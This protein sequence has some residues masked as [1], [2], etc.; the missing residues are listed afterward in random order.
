MGKKDYDQTLALL[1][2]ARKDEMA[3]KRTLRAELWLEYT[4]RMLLARHRV[5][6]LAIEAVAQGASLAAIGRAYGTSNFSTIKNLVA[7]A[8]DD[9]DIEAAQQATVVAK[10]PQKR[11]WEWDEAT[12]VLTMHEWTR[13]S[14]GTKMVEPLAIPSEQR[15]WLNGIRMWRPISFP[16]VIVEEVDAAYLGLAKLVGLG[17]TP[18]AEPEIELEGPEM[19]DEF[20]RAL[21]GA[22]EDAENGEES[23]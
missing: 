19:D 14:D 12:R 9:M 8:R 16:D 22:Y 20:S 21:W 10:E 5:S 4:N 7:L 18:D 2:E 15:P 3:M 23:E 1:S 13:R 6:R 17:A 11:T